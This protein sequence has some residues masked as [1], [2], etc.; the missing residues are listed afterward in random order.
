MLIV[1]FQKKWTRKELEKC[2][3]YPFFKATFYKYSTCRPGQLYGVPWPGGA[4]RQNFNQSCPPFKC[5]VPARSEREQDFSSF[6][7]LVSDSKVSLFSNN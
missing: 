7:C 3:M 6:N 5:P 1:G 4:V 2:T